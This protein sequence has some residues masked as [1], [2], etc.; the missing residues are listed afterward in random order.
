LSSDPYQAYPTSPA[1]SPTPRDEAK[2]VQLIAAGPARQR[3][4]TVGFRAVLVVPHILA[5]FFLGVAFLGIAFVGWWAALFTGRLPAFAVG[6]LSGLARWSA[7][8]NGYLFLLTDVY[9]PFAIDDDPGYPIVVAIPEPGRLNRSAVFFR[10]VLAVWACLV[11]SLVTAGASSIAL[12]IGWLITLVSGKLPGPLHLAFTAVLRY[13]TRYY[14]YLGLLTPTYPRQL[15]GDKPEVSASADDAPPLPPLQS[16]GWGLA[17]TRTA[18][19]LLVAFITLGLITVGYQFWSVGRLTGQWGRVVALIRWEAA[20]RELDA[21]MT[22]WQTA[23]QACN[24]DVVACLAQADGQAALSVSVFASQVQDISM[25]AAAAPYAAAAEG[26]A[27]KVA[28]DLTELS[29]ATTLTQYN[30][31]YATT[32][33]QADIANLYQDMDDTANALQ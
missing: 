14:C 26:D 9:P 28:Q 22:R 27:I 19:G 31:D 24:Q 17:L 15:F 30:M 33:V 7:R 2:A 32:L 5:L 18:K 16:A 12:F 23:T 20:T 8:V 13:Q 11:S 6:Y 25:P 3:R 21:N 10:L 4:L 1:W 29:Q